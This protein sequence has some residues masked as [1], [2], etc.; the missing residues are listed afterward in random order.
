MKG[1]LADLRHAA[2]LYLQTP[3]TSALAVLLVAAAMAIVT[4]FLSLFSDLALKPRPGF[5]GSRDIVTVGQSDGRRFNSVSFNFI[6]RVNEEA[7]NVE[8]MAGVMT[9]QQYIERPGREPEPISTE[10]VTREYFPLARPR[11]QVGRAFASEDHAQD[12]EPVA[13]LSNAFWRREF[14]GREN[15]LGETLTISGPNFVLRSPDGEARGR[16]QVQTYRIV[17]VLAPEIDG[18]IRDGTRVWMPYEQAAQVIFGGVGSSYLGFPFL[19]GLAQPAPGASAN[20]IRAELR[21]RFGDAGFE[22]GLQPEFRLDAIRGMVS[23]VNQQR[24]ALRQ[25]RLFLAGSVLLALVAASNVSLFLLSRAPGRRRELSIRM[26]VGAPLRRLAR[27]LFTESSLLVV[28]ATLLGV[29][30][31]VWMTVFIRGLAFLRQ[32]QFRNV[33]PFDWRVLGLVAALMLVLTVLVSLAPIVGLKKLGIA[34]GSR[35]ITARAG[36]GQR[37]AGTA[38][39]VAAT[40]IG[41]AALAF[42][43]YLVALAAADRGFSAPGVYLVN[44]MPPQS[45]L[46]PFDTPE[47][48]LL[49]E[50]E[51]RREVIAALPG[52]QEVGFA[53]SVPGQPR[54]MMRMQL[55]PP[56]APDDRFAAT[57]QTADTA[58]FDLLGVELLDGQTLDGADRNAVVINATLARRLWG[59][60][61]VA[62]E[63][64]PFGAA[65]PGVEPPRW[66]IA[67][68]IEDIAYGHPSIEADPMAYRLVAATTA[69]EWVLIRSDAT[70]ADL[71]RELERKIDEGELDFQIG[72]VRLVEDL[73]TGTLAPD[74][75][76]TTLTT[77]AALL[78]VVL[79]A[80]GFYGTQRYLVTA[81]RREY[82]ILAALG[83]GPRALGRLVF[84]RGLWQGVPGLVAG[85]LLAFSLVAWM[86]DDFVS[87]AVS[88]A[89]GTVAVVIG[90]AALLL[91]ATLGPARLV[92]RTEPAP[93]L[94]EE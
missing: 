27:Q 58:F 68:V 92:R 94:R 38:Q 63:V 2:R 5:D 47:D 83:A 41:A 74:R 37:L 80:F 57:I 77:V 61:D 12:A 31:S 85:G 14:N 23:D 45:G 84:R 18:T 34:A 42:I 46:P 82:A 6:E 15:V 90:M 10:L 54:L 89:A 76:R 59:R 39:V 16:D 93:L 73:W 17:G 25:V 55:T 69:L 44:V 29:L 50:R 72:S 51:H 35:S 62:G 19:T 81:G 75:A 65:P 36:W 32:A 56:E 1:L 11:M 71:Q 7:A 24:D 66:R 87:R 22:L 9:T 28:A 49:A 4:A 26:A 70:A 78:V 13:I 21:G 53:S 91:G 79:A 3:V 43:W 64:I 40:V 48:A 86:R 67:G 33:T 8:S 60:T 52:V 88:P 30:G 20:A